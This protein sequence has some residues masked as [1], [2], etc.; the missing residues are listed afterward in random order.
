M[1]LSLKLSDIDPAAAEKE[2]QREE[3]W[4]KTKKERVRRKLM[5]VSSSEDSRYRMYIMCIVHDIY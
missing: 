1:E 5:R 3:T 2:R 4:K